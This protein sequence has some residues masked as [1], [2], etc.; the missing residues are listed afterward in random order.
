MQ[1][2]PPTAISRDLNIL[3]TQQFCK[4]QNVQNHYNR[5]NQHAPERALGVK[6]AGIDTTPV[7]SRLPG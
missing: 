7:I 4:C 2:K 6:V 3:I 1:F 5:H